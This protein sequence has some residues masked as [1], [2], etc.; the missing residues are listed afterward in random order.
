[1]QE[2]INLSTKLLTQSQSFKLI[3]VDFGSLLRLVGLI[4]LILLL[5]LINIQESTIKIILKLHFLALGQ[6]KADFFYLV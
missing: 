5:P 4:N 3:W 6:L 2:S 1:M